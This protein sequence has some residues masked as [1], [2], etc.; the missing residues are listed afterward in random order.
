MRTGYFACRPEV[1][2]RVLRGLYQAVMLRTGEVCRG[3][4]E[5]RLSQLPLMKPCRAVVFHFGCPRRY[6]I[7]EAQKSEI[8]ASLTA[9]QSR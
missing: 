4:A 7:D 2:T 1:V 8:E 3:L 6:Y 5:I 9:F